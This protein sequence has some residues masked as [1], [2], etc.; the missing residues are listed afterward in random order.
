MRNVFLSVLNLSS[1]KLNNGWKILV[2]ANFIMF[3]RYD[4]KNPNGLQIADSSK[5]QDESGDFAGV[6]GECQLLH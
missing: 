3:R 5:S 6:W 2:L 1:T 4:S